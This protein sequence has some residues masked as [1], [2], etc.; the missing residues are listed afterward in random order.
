MAGLATAGLLCRIAVVYLVDAAVALGG[1]AWPSG[2]ASVT[3]FRLDHPTVRLGDHPAAHRDLLRVLGRLWLATLV[4]PG[5]PIAV[6]GR[7]R[8]AAVAAFATAH[9]GMALPLRL[10]LFPLVS[11][12]ALRP[13]LPRNVWDRV[14]RSRP[15][16]GPV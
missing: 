15:D 7:V 13:F 14:V 2:A 11:I 12:A 8:I 6:T 4:G 3:V 1:E 9:L 5:L 10:G 16:I